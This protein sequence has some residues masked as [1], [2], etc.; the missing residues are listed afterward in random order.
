MPNTNKDILLAKY[1]SYRTNHILHLI[2]SILTGGLW[3]VIWILC[4]ISNSIERKKIE[5]KINKM[6]VN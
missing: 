6:S 5:S 3:V 1:N 4:G 2:L